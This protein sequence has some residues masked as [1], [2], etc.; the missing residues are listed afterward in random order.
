MKYILIQAFLSSFQLKIMF[1]QEYWFILLWFKNV[2]LSSCN[3]LIDY[4]QDLGFEVIN[5]NHK[6]NFGILSYNDQ[7][8]FKNGR[9]HDYYDFS[10]IKLIFPG[11]YWGTTDC[12]ACIR[13]SLMFKLS[14]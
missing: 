9:D 3:K 7:L 12:D 6:R 14:L 11:N 4:L 5:I 13:S 1:F 2:P 10:D 8:E